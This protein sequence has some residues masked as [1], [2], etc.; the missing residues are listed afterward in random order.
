MLPLLAIIPGYVVR[1]IVVV[2]N[3]NNNLYAFVVYVCNDVCIYLVKCTYVH[4]HNYIKTIIKLNSIN[5][6]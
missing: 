4:V 3:N 6:H 2:A 1:R 5:I